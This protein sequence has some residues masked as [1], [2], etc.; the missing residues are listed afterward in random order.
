VWLR[1]LLSRSGAIDYCDTGWIFCACECLA[2]LWRRAPTSILVAAQTTMLQIDMGG[3]L[4]NRRQTL[5]LMPTAPSAAQ[6]AGTG[7]GEPH[8]LL[9]AHLPLDVLQAAPLGLRNKGMGKQRAGTGDGGID[10]EGGATAQH[11]VERQEGGCQQKHASP[12]DCAA[13]GDAL[14]HERALQ[15]ARCTGDRP[16]ARRPRRSTP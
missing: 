10:N 4:Y 8:S 2:P 6:P 15:T 1:W 7:S 16:P 9:L 14:W 5:P 13:E 11:I 3:Y 12:V